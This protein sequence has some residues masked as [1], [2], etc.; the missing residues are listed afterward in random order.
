LEFDK[1]QE[2]CIGYTNQEAIQMVCIDMATAAMVNYSL[3]PGMTIM[4]IKGEYVRAVGDV[5]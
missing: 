5:M 3:H 4:Y 2:P 1:L